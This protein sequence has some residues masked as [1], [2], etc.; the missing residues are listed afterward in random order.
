MSADPSRTYDVSTLDGLMAF[1]DLAFDDVYRCASRLT[2]GR[3]AAAE[4]LV[5]DAFVRLA[6]AV[7]HGDVSTVGVGW[8]ITAV[9]RLHIDG[10]R[11][12][13]QRARRLRLVAVSGRSESEP[14]F[15]DAGALL[16]GLTDRE[17][18]ALVFRYVEGLPVGEVAELI[19][20]TVR[21]TESLLQRAKHKARGSRRIS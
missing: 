7:R 4:D 18:A 21:A 17:R 1:Y 10:L 6:R 15:S 9:R 16:A 5:Q 3:H 20:A 19:G 2:R 13:E 11:S 14:T 8:L 12:D